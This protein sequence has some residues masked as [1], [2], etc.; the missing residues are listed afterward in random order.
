MFQ[1]LQKNIIIQVPS[2]LETQGFV[3]GIPYPRRQQ[4]KVLL[5]QIKIQNILQGE[6]IHPYG[7]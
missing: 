4:R 7:S 1:S 3:N 2:P 6:K 5:P